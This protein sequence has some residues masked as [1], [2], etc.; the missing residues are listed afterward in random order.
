[1][2]NPLSHLW[3]S[4][5]CCIRVKHLADIQIW[6]IIS[7]GI[8][9]QSSLILSSHLLSIY[10]EFQRSCVVLVT[11]MAI[12]FIK[13][14]LCARHCSMC[15]TLSIQSSQQPHA[16]VTILSSINRWGNWGTGVL[17]NMPTVTQQVKLVAFS[18]YWS[19]KWTLELGLTLN[20]SSA[21]DCVKLDNCS[22]L[23]CEPPKDIPAFLT[24]EPM[25]IILH[26]KR[27]FADAI[28]NLRTKSSWI[29]SVGPKLNEE[30]SSKKKK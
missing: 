13:C 7:E 23:N 15:L 16:V 25:T 1:M 9:P 24:L 3:L 4:G 30:C 22:G 29:T 2:F 8:V 28:K 20:P 11:I 14:I 27:A 17:N 18:P 10:P 21:T 6:Q 12:A 5:C 19:S 26:S